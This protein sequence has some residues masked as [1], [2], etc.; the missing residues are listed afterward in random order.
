MMYYGKVFTPCTRCGNSICFTNLYG[1][2][3]HLQGLT[4]A[5]SRA[6]HGK[7]IRGQS[8]TK[9]SSVTIDITPPVLL[10][11]TLLRD[12]GTVY[13]FFDDA[14]SIDSFNTTAVTLQV[15]APG[16]TAVQLNCTTAQRNRGS[17]REVA[18]NLAAPCLYANGTASGADSDWTVLQKAG[19]QVTAALATQPLL[20]DAADGLVQDYAVPAR[21]S[22]AVTALTEAGPNCQVCIL[23]LHHHG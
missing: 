12:T 16:A 21:A 15:A 10:R 13:L 8:G 11:H 14:V 7:D 3:T 2:V 19:L 23:S 1:P 9:A 22:P 18:L 20:L 4:G 6:V 17:L 5:P